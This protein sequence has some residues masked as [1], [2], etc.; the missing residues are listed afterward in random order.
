HASEWGR[1]RSMIRFSKP[2]FRRPNAEVRGSKEARVPKSG[3]EQRA[4]KSQARI[5][6]QEYKDSFC[7][8]NRMDFACDLTKSHHRPARSGCS[9]FGFRPSFGLRKLR[10]RISTLLGRLTTPDHPIPPPLHCSIHLF[11]EPPRRRD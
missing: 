8:E 11:H 10:L 5:W 4:G 2:I 9:E 1:D 7:S 3:V 6:R